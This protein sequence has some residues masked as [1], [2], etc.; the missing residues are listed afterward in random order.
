MKRSSLNVFQFWSPRPT[1]TPE[2]AAGAAPSR[3]AARIV[4]RVSLRAIRT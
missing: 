4:R 3:S 1:V 2:A